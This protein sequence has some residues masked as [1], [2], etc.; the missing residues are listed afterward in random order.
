MFCS[1]SLLHGSAWR[2]PRPE[3]AAPIL[4]SLVERL[5]D[6]S[7]TTVYSQAEVARSGQIVASTADWPLPAPTFDTGLTTPGVAAADVRGAQAGDLMAAVDQALDES[8]LKAALGGDQQAFARL[9]SRYQGAIGG[10]M[11]RFTREPAVYEEL[12]HDVFVEAYFSLAKYRGDAP[13]VHWLRRIATRV[14]YRYWK[15]RARRRSEQRLSDSQLA[16][17][18]DSRNVQPV[19]HDASERVF[20]L[21]GQLPPRDRLVL[22]LMYWDGCS[23]A[24]AADLTGWSQTMVKVQAFRARRKMKKL[25]DG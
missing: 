7:K 19:A 3:D 24:E 16:S 8:D 20:Q 18:T 12:V 9:V 22:T 14:G 17:L 15:Q 11:W 23:V 4:R 5:L 21:L 1:A 10:Q 13:L 2:W 6:F 25:L